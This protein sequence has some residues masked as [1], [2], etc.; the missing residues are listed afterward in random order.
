MTRDGGRLFPPE[1]LR[2]NFVKPQGKCGREGRKM[3]Y[4]TPEL[5][6]PIQGTSNPETIKTKTGRAPKT[7]GGGRLGIKGLA[8]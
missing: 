8:L 7:G 3:S 5:S 2:F 6:E 1:N 4:L